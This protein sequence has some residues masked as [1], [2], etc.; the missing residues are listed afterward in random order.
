MIS[1]KRRKALKTCFFIIT[2]HLIPSKF[3]LIIGNDVIHDKNN[4]NVSLTIIQSNAEC[5][6]PQV[7][8]LTQTIG[9][10][11]T[12]VSQKRGHQIKSNQTKP[13]QNMDTKKNQ[14]G[15]VFMHM[16]PHDVDL[17]TCSGVV[18]VPL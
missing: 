3:M 16:T 12:V 7:K 4:Q 6:D 18:A 8:C 2:S 13:N 1:R 17:C 14:S 10:T 5:F 9:F 11:F 15:M